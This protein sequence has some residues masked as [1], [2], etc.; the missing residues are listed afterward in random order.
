MKL[1][2]LQ[3][4]VAAIDEG[5]LRAAARRVGVT[6]PALSKMVR[7]LERE[8]G[9]P[10]LERST[11]GVTPTAQGRILHAR[12]KAAV[13][14]LDEA[15]QQIGQMGGRMVGQL[16][17]GAVPLALLLL[18]PEA[19]RTYSRAFPAM[20]L[21]LR[22]ELYIGQLELLRQRQ[23]DLVVGPIPED[24]APGECHVEPLMPIEMAVVVGRGN[25]K[26]RA[27]SLRDLQ[28]SRWVYTSLSGQ[29]GYAK[30]LFER[31]GLQPP[32]P[33][34]IVNSTLGLL[35]LISHGDCVGLM[36]LPIATHPAA[37]P[38]MQVLKLR[39]GPLPLALGAIALSTVAVKPAVRHFITHLHRAAAQVT[40]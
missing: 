7:E 22:E 18:V 24:L 19:V 5:S 27:R 14:E 21:Q 25:P 3:A 29:S 26:A 38:F 35:S 34:A 17:V 2:A 15:V 11:T 9:A 4:L 1:N 10:L 33:A 32:A 39:E 23:V 36:P 28:D 12:A 37:A 40:A 8:L 13:W 6:Q 30:L 31:H 16:A 20:M